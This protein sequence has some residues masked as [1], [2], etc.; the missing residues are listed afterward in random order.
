[1]AIKT[2]GAIKYQKN[3]KEWSITEAE[4]H[5]RIKLKSIFSRIG[6][7]HS[8]PYQ[9]PHSPEICSDLHWFML[10]Y[11]LLISEADARRIS[12]YHKINVQRINDL[13]TICLPDYEPGPMNLKDGLVA[14]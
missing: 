13:E 5:V 1:M 4:P 12:K 2:Y 9:F 3:K 14:R 7:T 11:P 10:R 8:P 6:K